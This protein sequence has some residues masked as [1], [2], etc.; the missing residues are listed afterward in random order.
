VASLLAPQQ[1]AIVSRLENTHAA[2]GATAGTASE[3]ELLLP[4]ARA[5]RYSVGLLAVQK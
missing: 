2:A 5:E 3:V 1:P 4:A